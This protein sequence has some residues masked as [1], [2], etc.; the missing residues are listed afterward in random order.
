MAMQSLTLSVPEM[1]CDGCEDIV[2]G[3]LEDRAGVDSVAANYEAGE[4]TVEGT[5]LSTPE[6]IEGVE[7]A[8]YEAT[9]DEPV[10][11]DSTAEAEPADEDPD[12]EE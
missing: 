12:G 3:A 7:F 5:D 6:L 10:G 1:G 4:V 9:V 8:G 11:A 2:E